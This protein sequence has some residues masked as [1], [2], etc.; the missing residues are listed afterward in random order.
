MMS[1]NQLT[2]AIIEFGHDVFQ[3][4]N[5]SCVILAGS[6]SQLSRGRQLRSDLIE[7][8]DLFVYLETLHRENLGANTSPTAL[9][10]RRCSS[11]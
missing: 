3:S 1:K 11:G 4:L 10:L 6:N 7:E 9:F 8:V 2:S 5:G